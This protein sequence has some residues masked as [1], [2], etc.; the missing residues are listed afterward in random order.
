MRRLMRSVVVLCFAAAGVVCCGGVLEAQTPGVP[1]RVTGPVVY[2]LQGEVIGDRVRVRASSDAADAVPLIYAYKGDKMRV[3][4][5]EGTWYKVSLPREYTMWV[6]ERGADGSRLVSVGLDKIAVVDAT[7]VAVRE[8]PGINYQTSGRLQRGRR[9]EIVGKKAGWLKFKFVATDHGF[10]SK[11]YIKLAGDTGPRPPR[12]P[13]KPVK[14][15]VKPVKPPV[16]PVVPVDLM[17]LFT[18]A[19]AAYKRETA[20]K[21]FKDWDLDEAEK[22]YRAVLARTRNTGLIDRSRARLRVIELAN[23]QKATYTGRSPREL[24]TERE[25]QIDSEFQRKRE[26]LLKKYKGDFPGLLA[27]GEMRPMANRLAPIT[28][29]LLKDG[30]M[31]HM[32]Y[33]ETINL[34]LYAGKTVG[35]EGE[36]DTNLKWPIPTIRVTGLVLNPDLLKGDAKRE[37]PKPVEGSDATPAPVEEKTDTT[38]EPDA[39]H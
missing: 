33:S 25:R 9:V 5:D 12:P 36:V 7:D 21:D 35:V 13:V 34:A 10:V 11:R 15:P 27:I 18:R 28:H 4:S 22:L 14:P 32:L 17:T 3:L 37:K 24:L 31:T 29:K 26:Q 8:G 23:Q 2:P 1:V 6:S 30:R 16:K 20:K 39:P 38:D 19:E